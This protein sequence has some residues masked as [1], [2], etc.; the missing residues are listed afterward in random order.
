MAD[1]AEV[2]RGEGHTRDQMKTEGEMGVGQSYWPVSWL[3]Q[4]RVR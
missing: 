3:A 4:S 1:A 2:C